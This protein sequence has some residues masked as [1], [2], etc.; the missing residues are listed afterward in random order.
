MLD[1]ALRP[2]KDRLLTPLA[3]ALAPRAHPNT[4]SLLGFVVG[5]GCAALLARG[6]TLPALA[7]WAVNRLLDG[8]DGAVARAR[9][10][11]TD[12]GGYLDLLLDFVLYALLPLAAAAG[13]ELPSTADRAALAWLVA[14]LLGT[15]YVN[16]ASWM[17]LA[18]VLEK[19]SAGAAARSELTSITMPTGLVE[20]TETIIFYSLFMLFPGALGP[21]MIIM[22]AGVWLT[23]A[24]RVAWA[25]R[26][27]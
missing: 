22:L 11:P 4:L 3:E 15:F 26:H 13:V 1:P 14:A 12:L 5:L 18:A 19:R 27:L 7:L 16:A 8:L 10:A 9:H 6:A 24:Q 17:Y 25:L 23:I 2:V 21:L 20:G